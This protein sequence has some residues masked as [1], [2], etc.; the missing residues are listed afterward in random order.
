MLLPAR[1][2]HHLF[3]EATEITTGGV[4][5]SLLCLIRAVQW[6]MVSYLSTPGD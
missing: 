5:C 4:L 1:T 3:G 2:Q 6:A